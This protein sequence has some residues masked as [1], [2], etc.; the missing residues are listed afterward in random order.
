MR[1][2]QHLAKSPKTPTELASLED[3]HLSEISRMLRKLR[4]N[5]LVVYRDSGSRERYYMATVE[6]YRIVHQ[7]LR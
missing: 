3:K 7:R 1:L 2:L 4:D 5:G 6:G